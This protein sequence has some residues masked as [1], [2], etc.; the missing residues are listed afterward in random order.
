MKTKS[1]KWRSRAEKNIVIK[2]IYNN[3]LKTLSPSVDEWLE[4]SNRKRS[5]LSA[6][7]N[8]PKIKVKA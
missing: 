2:E 5:S 8:V 7:H 6:L 1:E 3:P 4:M